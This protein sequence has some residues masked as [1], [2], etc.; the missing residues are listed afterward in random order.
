MFQTVIGKEEEFGKLMK[1]FLHTVPYSK[2]AVRKKDNSEW[3]MAAEYETFHACSWNLPGNSFK[4]CIILQKNDEFA[5]VQFEDQERN[6]EL[7]HR[8][9]RLEDLVK[10]DTSEKR[11][12]IFWIAEDVT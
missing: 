8:I 12:E 7:L 4:R 10:V 3:D 1:A 6:R 5:L 11:M 2:T 9:Y